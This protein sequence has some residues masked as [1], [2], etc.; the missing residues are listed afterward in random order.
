MTAHETIAAHADLAR[1]LAANPDLILDPMRVVDEIE[2]I[3]DARLPVVPSSAQDLT[4]S[5]SRR[6]ARRKLAHSL[7]A[8]CDKLW[9]ARRRTEA[10]RAR[11]EARKARGRRRRAANSAAGFH[12]EWAD[13]QGFVRVEG[14]VAAEDA[15]RWRTALRMQEL[16]GF[17]PWGVAPADA[18]WWAV[19]SLKS[20]IE[21]ARKAG[22]APFPSKVAAHA[23]LRLAL[24]GEEEL[25]RREEKE[26]QDVAGETV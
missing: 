22:Y 8:K 16:G 5:R 12:R 17:D 6:D 25:A 21:E 26:A 23:V 2:R 9:R 19:A 20:E 13:N 1:T 11:A 7:Q 14:Y 18:L 10:E 3:V 24:Y 4:A 15:A